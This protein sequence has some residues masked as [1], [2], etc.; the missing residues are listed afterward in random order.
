MRAKLAESIIDEKNA[1]AQGEIDR[2]MK[3]LASKIYHRA[4]SVAG[5]NSYFDFLEADL[6][7]EMDAIALK[8]G[9]LLPRTQFVSIMHDDFPFHI[10]FGEVAP[11]PFKLYS[12][13]EN[14]FKRHLEDYREDLAD[15]VTVTREHEMQNR[16]AFDNLMQF[17]N[18]TSSPAKAA[19]A[20]PEIALYFPNEWK[21]ESDELSLTLDG[22]IC[23]AA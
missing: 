8:A 5:L 23:N 11:V 16:V 14:F 17:L 3:A 18:K 4:C 20:L 19:L 10:D 7:Y 2:L 12:D 9:E 21:E 1:I 6:D 15:L 22:V 13:P